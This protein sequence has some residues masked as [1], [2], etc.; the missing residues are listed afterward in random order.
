LQYGIEEKKTD[1]P[2]NQTLA[3]KIEAIQL[4]KY[5]KL[6]TRKICPPYVEKKP[7]TKKPSINRWPSQK[8]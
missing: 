2:K 3:I 6:I 7:K 5:F 8:R 1:K 4:I